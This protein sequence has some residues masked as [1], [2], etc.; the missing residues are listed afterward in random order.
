MCLAPRADFQS[1]W[2]P[3]EGTG[4]AGQH[5]ED[6]PAK[7]SKG[8]PGGSVSL[9]LG[10]EAIRGDGHPTVR[11][12]AEHVGQ[13]LSSRLYKLAGGAPMWVLMNCLGV[14][15]QNL[16]AG[17]TPLPAGGRGG[18]SPSARVVAQPQMGRECLAP[19]LVRGKRSGDLSPQF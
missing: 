2:P 18:P 1:C 6:R 7:A 13:W 10:L 3:G 14:L 8:G 11:S 17:F 4:G 19:C 9:C 16:P 5:S 12:C 15:S